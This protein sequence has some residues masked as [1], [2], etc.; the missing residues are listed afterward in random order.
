[1]VPF[2][3]FHRPSRVVLLDDDPIF[4]EML[5]LSLPKKWRKALFSQPE[6]CLDFLRT[7]VQA[8]EADFAMQRQLLSEVQAGASLIPLVLQYWKNNPA[9]Y[10]HVQLA[11]FDYS[12]PGM[13]GV[14]ALRTIGSWNGRRVLFRVLLT[15]QADERV[16]VKAFNDDLIDLYITKQQSGLRAHLAEVVQPLLDK[17]NPSYQELWG[18]GLS[19]L[20]QNLLSDPEVALALRHLFAKQQWVEYVVTHLPFGVLGVDALGRVSWLQLELTDDTMD[21]A[22]LVQD[23]WAGGVRLSPQE[24][25]SLRKGESLINAELAI[26]L[27]G[28]PMSIRPALQ[29]GG[30]LLGAM[31][32]LGEAYALAPEHSYEAWCAHNPG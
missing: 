18:Q 9:R 30:R 16:A 13:T 1:M 22:E 12:L 32:D 25:A 3:F 26:A 27:E 31:Y 19:E 7:N 23:G 20:Q 10:A 24:R 8:W 29:I 21:W 2:S 5:S 4:L 11:I 28:V 17:P 14:D 6:S 15:G